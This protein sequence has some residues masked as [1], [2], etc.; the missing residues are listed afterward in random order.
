MT[1]YKLIFLQESPTELLNISKVVASSISSSPELKKAKI[2]T[3]EKE[4][5]IKQ[6]QNDLLDVI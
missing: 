5:Q 4:N 1:Q 3:K 6:G 2:Q